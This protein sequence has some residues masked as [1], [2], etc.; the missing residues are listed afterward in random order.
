M[1]DMKQ[2]NY[3]NGKWLAQKDGRTFPVLNPATG[4]TVGEVPDCGAEETRE[5]IEAAAEAFKTWSRTTSQERYALLYRVYELVRQ[6][7]DELARIITLE[8]G[9]P[10]ADAKGE[11]AY[12]NS[13]F[14]WYAEEAKRIYGETIPAL[15]PNKRITVIRQPVGVVGAITPWNYPFAMIARKVSA[16]LAAGCTVVAKPSEDTPLTA[17]A[18]CEILEEAGIPAGVV[19]L[20]TGSPQAIGGEMLANPLVRK[21]TFTGSTQVGKHLIRGSAEH[22]KKVSMELGGHAP[23]IVFDDADIDAAVAGALSVKFKNNGQACVCGNRFFIHRPI[24]EEFSAKFIEQTKKYKVGIGTEEGTQIGPLINQKGLAKVETHVADALAKGAVLAAGGKRLTAGGLD[25]GWFYEPTVLLN[26]NESMQI[27]YEETFGPVAPLIPFETEEE[28]IRRANDSV[29]GLAAYVYTR[30]AGR[31]VRVSEALEYGM[32]GVNDPGPAVAYQAPFGG[33][34]QSGLG[35]EG[36]RQG[37]MEFLE[38]KYIS[39][40]FE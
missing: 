34:K 8:N 32:V 13:Y 20:V 38:E 5:A 24:M 40:Q 2:L 31:V 19:N 9:K 15:V 29:Y 10:L 36:G 3:I 26:V 16:A 30:D 35:R 33:M 39:H 25:R 23:F 27:F 18:L 11:I 37:L 21:M 7:T 14:L 12:G 22:V 6:R 4:E 17:I 28:A 1:V